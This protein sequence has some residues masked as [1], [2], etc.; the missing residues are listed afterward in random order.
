MNHLFFSSSSPSCPNS[1]LITF[2]LLLVFLLLFPL[3]LLLHLLHPPSYTPVSYSPPPLPSF[4]FILLLHFL[5]R[6]MVSITKLACHVHQQHTRGQ[7][8]SDLSLTLSYPPH[9]HHLYLCPPSKPLPLSLPPPPDTHFTYRC[10]LY[11]PTV[12]QTVKVFF[13]LFLKH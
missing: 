7:V 3:L 9:P 11:V 13:F 5:L 8:A 12:I 4:S 1:L 2:L 6:Q 10:V